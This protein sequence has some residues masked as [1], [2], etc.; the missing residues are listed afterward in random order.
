MDNVSISWSKDVVAD[1]PSLSLGYLK[2]IGVRVMP[3]NEAMDQFIREKERYLRSKYRLESLKDVPIIRKYRDFFWRMGIDPTKVRPASEA[4][5]RRI[6]R[7]K[8]LP[9][10]SNVVDAYNLASVESLITLSAYD[11]SKI[12]PPLKV[13]YADT[14][15]EVLLIGGR[16]RILNG[17]EIVLADA[18]GILCVY[19]HGD[20]ERSKVRR[21]TREL[22]LVAYGA[23]SIEEEYLVKALEIA[24]KYIVRFSGGTPRNIV[25][26][27]PNKG[28][29]VY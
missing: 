14:N 26:S 21:S 25:I 8:G 20:A 27:S 3:R 18:S 6:L 10:I 9:R 2:I 1:F 24:M 28:D 4:L 11:L 23:P 5:L 7:G 19:V 16:R 29:L 15:E 13:R 17:E 22:L 12:N